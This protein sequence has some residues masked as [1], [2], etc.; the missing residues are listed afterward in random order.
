M[1]SIE[2]LQRF[3][4]ILIDSVDEYVMGDQF[5]DSYWYRMMT[6]CSYLN[7][8]VVHPGVNEDYPDGVVGVRDDDNFWA[9]A[10]IPYEFKNL[11]IEEIAS[12]F[13][14]HERLEFGPDVFE[15][16]EQ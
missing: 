11:A 3:K 5:D 8:E 9:I 4:D 2:K 12:V 14:P 15:G 6:I 16:V 10:V 7:K 1:S 13:W